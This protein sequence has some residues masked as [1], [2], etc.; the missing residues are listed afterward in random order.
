M[1]DPAPL[2]AL[3]QRLRDEVIAPMKQAFVAKDEVIDLL[4]LP[5]AQTISIFFG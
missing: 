4:G 1:N 3:G 2:L 5:K